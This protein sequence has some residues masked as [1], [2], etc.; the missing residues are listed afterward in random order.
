MR[1]VSCYRQFI[2]TTSKSR[3]YYVTIISQKVAVLVCKVLDFV[4]QAQPSNLGRG[5]LRCV[6]YFG[7]V[8]ARLSH[9]CLYRSF[10][11]RIVLT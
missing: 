5:I 1:E 10:G 9:I 7:R 2:S 6:P 8:G 3:N 4:S 11:E